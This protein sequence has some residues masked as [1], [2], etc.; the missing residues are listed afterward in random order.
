MERITLTIT[1][2][3]ITDQEI[4]RGLGLIVTKGLKQTAREMATEMSPNPQKEGETRALKTRLEEAE[5]EILKKIQ[6][7]AALRMDLQ[8]EK[9]QKEAALKT[10]RGL[11]SQVE[12]LEDKVAKHQDTISK[13][14]KK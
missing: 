9:D 7:V 1:T 5:Q 14:G 12:M 11:R 4:A 13:M 8:R 6:T 10:V 3:E 2:D